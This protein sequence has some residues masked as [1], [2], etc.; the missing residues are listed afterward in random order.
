MTR[1][2]I[3]KIDNSALILEKEK[4]AALKVIEDYPIF[5]ELEQWKNGMEITVLNSDAAYRK[6]QFEGCS[7]PAEL[8][9]KRI[10]GAVLSYSETQSKYT[11][12]VELEDDTKY[13]LRF[14]D[15]KIVKSQSYNCAENTVYQ[16]TPWVYLAIIAWQICDKAAIA[17]DMLNQKEQDLLPLLKELEQFAFV[18]P[19]EPCGFPLLHK[20]AVDNGFED[21]E[22]FFKKAQNSKGKERPVSWLVLQLSKL[23]YKHL[24]DAVYS[25]IKE[26]QQDY[27]CL[28]ADNKDHIKI[29]DDTMHEQGF[30]GSFPDYVKTG[31][32]KKSITAESYGSTHT[33]A[34]GKNAVYR[35]HCQESIDNGELKG[36]TFLCGT[37]ILKEDMSTDETDIYYCAFD[38][39]GKTLFDVIYHYT[40]EDYNPQAFLKTAATVA[41]KRAQRIKLNK[42][43]KAFFNRNAPSF[44]TSF[45]TVF[46]LLGGFFSIGFT[47]LSFIIV[48]ITALATGENIGE[49]LKDIPWVFVIV[50]TWVGFGGAMGIITALS[51][52]K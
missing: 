40:Y 18:R 27:P 5:P 6:I 7:A 46:I 24:W 15:I 52:R 34:K 25:K 28:E 1:D 31:I 8:R 4:L 35:V 29:I 44:M 38:S 9:D 22:K 26:S 39:K 48:V 11:L 3:L 42:S 51:N 2:A 32:T 37:A 33:V 36:I 49:F 47:L 30:E 43:E 12:A 21:L 45:L 50:S 23:R 41:A 20:L 14:T 19:N 13:Y 16:A 17:P 10:K